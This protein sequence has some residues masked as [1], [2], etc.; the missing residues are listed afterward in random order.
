V[1]SSAQA[2]AF[3]YHISECPHSLADVYIA[4]PS[5]ALDLRME[6]CRELWAAGISAD[7]MYENMTSMTPDRLITTCKA[8]GIL[9]VVTARPRHGTV[10]IKNVLHRSE[11]EVDRGELVYWLQEN[12]SRQRMVDSQQVGGGS[13]L[14]LAH[15]SKVGLGGAM[16]PPS[17]MPGS[18]AGMQH[19]RAGES[20]ITC[21]VVMQPLKYPGKEDRSGRN[22]KDRKQ[23]RSTKQVIIDKATRD[24]QKLSEEI[25]SGRVPILAVDLGRVETEKLASRILG[26]TESYRAYLDSLSTAAEKDYVKLI[27]SQLLAALNADDRNGGHHGSSAERRA[28]LYSVRDER[29]IL[30]Q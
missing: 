6:I 25:V 20:N 16:M 1:V 11:Q 22:N 18:S 19:L 7:L 9:F 5:G 12:L 14:H 30:I 3:S 15:G 8:E 17:P 2:S 13:G 26:D 21:Q 10:K 4:S 28:I 24:A 29:T 23:S 27:K